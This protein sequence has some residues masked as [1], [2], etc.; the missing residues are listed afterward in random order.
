MEHHLTDEKKYTEKGGFQVFFSKQQS[1]TFNSTLRVID[2][3]FNETNI[4]CEGVGL[5]GSGIFETYQ[6]NTSICL[7]GKKIFVLFS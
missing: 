2:V 4:S 1:G 5:L 6:E 7:V 3:E